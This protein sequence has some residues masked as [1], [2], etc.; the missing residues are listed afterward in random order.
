MHFKFEGVYMVHQSLLSAMNQP[1]Y[2]SQE[3][4]ARLSFTVSPAVRS[5]HFQEVLALRH[6]A[7]SRHDYKDDLKTGM[8]VPDEADLSGGSTTLVAVCK[9]S[10]KV[11]GTVRVTASMDSPVPWPSDTPDDECLLEP[12]TYIDR[13]AVAQGPESTGVAE[14]LIKGIYLW[15]LGRDCVW[16]VALALPLLARLYRRRGGMVV[17]GE[18]APIRMEEYHTDAYLLLGTRLSEVRDRLAAENPGYARTFFNKT[19]PDIAVNAFAAPW[20]DAPRARASLQLVAN[21]G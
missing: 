17:R 3:S 18:G 1:R 2:F 7:Y 9:T 10:N 4:P 11:L 14:A 12:Y 6:Q 16:A 13:F 20:P 8:L 5:E 15:S 19:H 21:N